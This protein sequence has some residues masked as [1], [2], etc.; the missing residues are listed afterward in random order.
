VNLAVPIPAELSDADAAAVPSAHA[1]AWYS[2]HNLARISAGDKVLIHSATGGVG[3]A[4]LAIARAAGAEIY[5]TAGST[6]RRN[7]LLD[8][9]VKGVYDS[10]T[11]DFADQ[12]R[13]DTDGYGVDIVLNSLPGAAQR[14]GIELLTFGGRFIEIGK[15]DIYGD[16]KMGLFPF[17]RNLSFHAVDLALLA[18]VEPDTL[19]AMLETIYQQLADGVLPPPQTT[20]YPLANG[21][22]AIRAMAAAEHTGKLVLDV[23]RAVSTP[24][25]CL[26]T[27]PRRSVPTVRT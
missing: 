8:M 15:R 25:S 4:A 23:P 27:G 12:I 18:L 17:R 2:L 16:T 21:A 22:N 13:A 19:R 5:A 1:T 6:E 10:R 24:P 11:I 26:P 3:Q 14:A 7:M 20:R 9:G